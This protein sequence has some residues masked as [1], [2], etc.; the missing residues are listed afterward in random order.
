MI[1]CHAVTGSDSTDAP[2]EDATPGPEAAA[3]EQAR[4]R[5]A[6]LAAVAVLA[7]LIG[8]GA[9]TAVFLAIGSPGRSEHRFAVR[10]FLDT[11]A[12]ADQKAA[13]EAALPAFEPS[14]DVTFVSRE[15]AWQ[16]FQDVMKD[17]PDVLKVAKKQDLPESFDFETTGRSFDCAEYASVRQMPGVD[18]VQVIQDRVNGYFIVVTC[19]AEDAAS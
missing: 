13:V 9:A 18:R 17:R 3:P 15:A 11:D 12:T 5:R 19:V 1:A 8:A 14:G 10:V 6:L 7:M 16:K 4:P 2:L